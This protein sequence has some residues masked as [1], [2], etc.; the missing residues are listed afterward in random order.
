VKGFLSTVE[1]LAFDEHGD[2]LASQVLTSL[3]LRGKR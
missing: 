2:E 1:I 3:R